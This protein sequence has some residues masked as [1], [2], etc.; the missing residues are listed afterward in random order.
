MKFGLLEL[1]E[2]VIDD[3]GEKKAVVGRICKKIPPGLYC[4]KF[5]FGCLKMA[6]DNLQESGAT[7]GP[8]CDPECNAGC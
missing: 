8:F 1:V 7:N 4:V 5:D 3:Q 2:T 6:E